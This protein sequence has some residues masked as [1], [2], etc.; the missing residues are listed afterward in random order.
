[1]IEPYQRPA[2]PRGRPSLMPASTAETTVIAA[3]VI[4]AIKIALMKAAEKNGRALSA[5]IEARLARTLLK[6]ELIKHTKRGGWKVR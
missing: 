1:M 2:S 3:R 6:D 4:G 5:E